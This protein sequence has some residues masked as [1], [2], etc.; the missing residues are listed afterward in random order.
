M[1]LSRVPY[2]PEPVEL[3]WALRCLAEN[4]R[5]TY[6]LSLSGTPIALRVFK[7][8]S[9]PQPG[10]VVLEISRPLTP[11]GELDCLGQL[12]FIAGRKPTTEAEWED[13]ETQGRWKLDSERGRG[14]YYII[15]PL[16][17]SQRNCWENAT[18][19]RVSPKLAELWRLDSTAE[20]V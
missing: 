5:A 17:G 20:V 18:F 7:Y 4:A 11:G 9:D 6:R 10:D 12:L 8:L 1:S 14:P 2:H 19:I 13:A 15:D 3:S 16:D